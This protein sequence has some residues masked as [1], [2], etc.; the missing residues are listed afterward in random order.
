MDRPEPQTEEEF[1]RE[2]R[3]A[4]STGQGT[5][6]RTNDFAE[7]LMT[8]HGDGCLAGREAMLREQFGN[9]AIRRALLPEFGDDFLGRD[10][11]LEFLRT[12]RC[13]L[14]DRLPDT[15]WIK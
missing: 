11:V 6:A 7:H 13:K 5:P 1:E 15:G 9:R 4:Y 2:F 12:A 10:Q 8:E 14:R 3:R